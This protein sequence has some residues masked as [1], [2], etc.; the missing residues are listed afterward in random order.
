VAEAVLA[1]GSLRVGYINGAMPYTF[2]NRH[3]QLVGFDV[4]MADALASEM[5]VGLELVPVSRD[6]MAEVLDEGLCDVVMA[7]VAVT[8]SRGSRTAFSANYIDETLAFV[9]PDYRRADFS[10]AEWIRANPGLKVAVP[11]IPYLLDLVQREFPGVVALPLP[12]DT[13]KA[14]DYLRSRGDAVDAV[15]LT[16][17]RGSFL[18][19][20]HPAYSVAVPHPVIL[21]I[22]L[23]YPVAR[24]DIEFARFLS[25]WIDLKQKDGTIPALYNHWILGQDARPPRPHWSILR[26]VLHWSR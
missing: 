5:G 18:T 17:E 6:R 23:A 11:D 25:H 4:E 8:T 16:A 2:I 26:D 12:L 24:H 13:E 9:V 19:L 22:P 14:A 3:G 10:S 21:K 7:G 1:R 20:L 15:A